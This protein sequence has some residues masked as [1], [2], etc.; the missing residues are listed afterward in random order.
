MAVW[1]KAFAAQP[2]LSS[3]HQESFA[4]KNTQIPQNRTAALKSWLLTTRLMS[5]LPGERELMR[6]KIRQGS[7]GE[8]DWGL[9][10][11]A[12]ERNDIYTE[13]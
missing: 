1:G 13:T 8:T 2:H 6:V 11:L 5:H 10:R 9:L 3:G 7:E 4:V 12:G